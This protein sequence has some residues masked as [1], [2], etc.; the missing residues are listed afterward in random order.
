MPRKATPLVCQFLEK[1]SGK[2]LEK[3]QSI[4]R[5]YVYRR[6]G[7]YALYKR[8][9]LY[10]VG[11]A[12]NLR[13]RLRG[14]LHDRHKGKW[15]RFSI[16]ITIGDEHIKELESLILR[17]VPTPGNKQRGKFTRADNLLSQLKKKI[18]VRA[19]K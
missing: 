14:H 16:Y 9:R 12:K 4:I 19:T 5:E 2:V 17:M 1:A 3:Y 8:E 11:L 15:D 13:G 10:Y 6:H 7:V 18:S